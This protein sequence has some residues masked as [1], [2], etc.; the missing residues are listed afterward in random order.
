MDL[1]YFS[2]DVVTNRNSGALRNGTAAWPKIIRTIA[3]HDYKNVV[4]MTDSDMNN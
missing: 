1:Y 3:S 4:M 2:D